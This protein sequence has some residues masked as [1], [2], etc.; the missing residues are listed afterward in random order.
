MRGSPQTRLGQGFLSAFG[1][2]C[3]CVFFCCCPSFVGFEGKSKGKPFWRVQPSRQTHFD[4]RA[5]ASEELDSCTFRG[6]DEDRKDRQFISEGPWRSNGAE[7]PKHRRRYLLKGI[8]LFVFLFWLQRE[9]IS[10]LDLFLFFS[11]RRKI[12][13]RTGVLQPSD[14]RGRISTC[15]S[16]H[17]LPDPASF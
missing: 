14:A 2:V 17:C 16:A 6:S 11:R 12:K 10:L 5:F 9:S 4:R 15:S 8:F 7:T 1:C 3:V 13:W